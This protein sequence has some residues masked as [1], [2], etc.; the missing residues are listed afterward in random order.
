MV[1]YRR[2]TG[3][4][5]INGVFLPSFGSFCSFF[6]TYCNFAPINGIKAILVLA[7]A[8]QEFNKLRLRKLK[9]GVIR[10]LAYINVSLSSNLDLGV[11]LLVLLLD[12]NIFVPVLRISPP[13]KPTF[14]SFL[15]LSLI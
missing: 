10:S 14:L 12:L 11:Y 1:I 2:K 13:Q 4:A 15:F 8:I 6:S 9:D 7:K 3:K 5:P